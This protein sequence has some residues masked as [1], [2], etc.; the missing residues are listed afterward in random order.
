[1]RDPVFGN[2]ILPT[3]FLSTTVGDE[4][5]TGLEMGT[6]LPAL[7]LDRVFI[8]SDYSTCSSSELLING[9]R[10]IGIE[11][12]LIGG[13]TCG[14][15][16]GGVLT[17]NCGTSYYMIQTTTENARGFGDYADGFEPTESFDIG[18]RA[19]KGC[20]VLDSLDG[21]LGSASENMLSVALHY[22]E[23][24]SCPYGT[25][26]TDNIF[27][28]RTKPS[29]RSLQPIPIKGRAIMNYSSQN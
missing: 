26:P 19:V 27:A 1:M 12:I 14:K 23:N 18:H 25:T 2:E 11:V 3:P 9:L 16:Y 24:G 21:L 15:P 4:A 13:T 29:L 8:I 22:I 28:K 6:P 5:I 10:G 17:D 20:S 7:D